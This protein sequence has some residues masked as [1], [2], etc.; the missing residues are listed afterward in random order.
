MSVWN[1]YCENIPPAAQTTNT[2]FRWTQ[3]E[4]TSESYDH[5]GMDNVEIT[6]PPDYAI[7]CWHMMVI[8]TD[9]EID[10]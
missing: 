4:A 9:K 8:P 10:W 5:W 3:L 1:Q 6:S 2:M 7:Y